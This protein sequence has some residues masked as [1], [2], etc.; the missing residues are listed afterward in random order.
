MEEVCNITEDAE[1]AKSSKNP[2]EEALEFFE[3]RM[4]LINEK[5]TEKF[6]LRDEIHVIQAALWTV[7]AANAYRHL[8]EDAV[9][10][11]E[12]Y[13]ENCAHYAAYEMEHKDDQR[14]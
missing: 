4:A 3:R 9:N 10:R 5:P 6:E 7:K 14:Q 2:V 11:M 12:R 1:K 8:Y 13:R